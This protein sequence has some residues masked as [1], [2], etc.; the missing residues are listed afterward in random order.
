MGGR[1]GDFATWKQKQFEKL[2]RYAGSRVS[3]ENAEARLSVCSGCPL[4]GKVQVRADLPFVDGCTE[5]QCPF[6]TKAYMKDIY[7]K[8]GNEDEPLSESEI[9][10]ILF[11]KTF[12]KKKIKRVPIIC[13][14]KDGNRWQ[15]VDSQFS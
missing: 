2:I 6:A 7:R 12:D 3:K 10:Q 11:Y 4:K 14:H 13:P 8:I 15:E 5:C 9:K 1:I